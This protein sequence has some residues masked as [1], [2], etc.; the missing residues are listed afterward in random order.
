M[1]SKVKLLKVLSILSESDAKHPITASQICAVLEE[2]GFSAERKS[3][4]RDINTLI[5]NGYKI[6]LCHDNKLGYFMEKSGTKIPSTAKKET[7]TLEYRKENEAKVEKIFGKKTGVEDSDAVRAVFQVNSDTL[8]SK[9]LEAGDFVQ[10][11]SPEQIR[12]EFLRLVQNTRD[13]YNRPKRDAKI[14]VW[15][16]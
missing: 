14:D 16:L 13:Y 7:V 15:L 6:V 5:S 8:F 10:I 12:E 11:T 4:C 3:V 1:Q 2:Q 9:L